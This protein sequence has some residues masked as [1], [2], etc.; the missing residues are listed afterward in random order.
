MIDPPN[1]RLA[2]AMK[3]K[4]VSRLDLAVALGVTEHTIRRLEKPSE[5]IPTKHALTLAAELGVEPGYLMGWD[6]S[7]SKAA[8]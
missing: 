1:N 2:K 4:G 7:D 6:R 3:D 8:A 5:L